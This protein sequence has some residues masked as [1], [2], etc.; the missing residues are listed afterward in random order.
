MKRKIPQ[1]KSQAPLAF[2]VLHYLLEFAQIHIHGVSDAFQSP[3]LAPS[4]LALNLSQHQGI[5]Q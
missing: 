4:P 1:H 3:L 2:I 5:F